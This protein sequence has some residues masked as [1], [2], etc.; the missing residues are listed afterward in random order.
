MIALEDCQS[1]LQEI[2][3]RYERW[4]VENALTEAISDRQAT[5]SFEQMVQTEEKDA[6]GQLKK[7][8]PLPIFTAIQNYIESEHILLVGSPGVGKSTALWC[9]LVQL[10]E[11]EREKPEPRIPVLISLKRYNNRFSCPEDPSGILALIKDTLEPDL[12]L[13]VPDIRKLLFKD[14]R[15]ILLLDG[16]NEMSAGEKRTE[17]EE[18]RKK[19]DRSK[20]PLIC[21]TRELGG[22]DL[23]IKRRLEIQP[24]ISEEVAR[25]LQDCIPDRKQK[26]SQLLNRDNRPLSRTPFVLWMLY[27]LFQKQGTKVETLAEAFRQFFQS[28]KKY[29]E[30]APVSEDRRQEWNRW[31]EHL[32]FTMLNHPDP[33]DP[34]LV[35]SKE[36]A[37]KSLIEKFGDLYGASS[38]IEELLKYHLLEE[39][40]EKEISFHHQLIQ[41]YYAA[42]CLLTRLP[43]LLK[44][45]RGQ[46]YTPFQV[47]YLNYVK[48][49]EAIA[50]MLGFPEVEENAEQ[51]I[52]SALD[53]DLYLT[54][55]LA[56]EFNLEAQEKSLTLLIS[57]CDRRD[58]SLLFKVTC[59]NKSRSKHGTQILIKALYE[60]DAETQ[61]KA[62][63]GLREV[64]DTAVIQDLLRVIENPDGRTYPLVMNVIEL[65]AVLDPDK[66]ISPKLRELLKSE[67]PGIREIAVL[68][69]R[70]LSTE[71]C[72][73]D[74]VSALKDPAIRLRKAVIGALGE[75]GWQEIVPDLLKIL[76]GHGEEYD[77]RIFSTAAFAL[78]KLDAE[79]AFSHPNAEVRRAAV[80]LLDEQNA[81]IAFSKLRV[82][83]QDE[84]FVV[85]GQAVGIVGRLRISEL[86][87]EVFLALEDS[88]STVQMQAAY[89]LG[90]LCSV[91]AIPK[92]IEKLKAEDAR[93]RKA[94]IETIRNLD[95]EE[96]VPGLFTA[97][98]DSEESVRR[99]A[100]Y[101]LGQLGRRNAIPHFIEI[102]LN[103]DDE[104]H[105]I[106]IRNYLQKLDPRHKSELV[107]QIKSQD[108]YI[109]WDA[110]KT[111]ARIA[112][113]AA[114]PELIRDFSEEK[115][116]GQRLRF[117]DSLRY[118]YS[119][120]VL[121]TLLDALNDEE[122]AIRRSAALAIRH[123]G[124]Y[125]HLR[126]LWRQQIRRPLEAI[127]RAISAI[128]SHC[129]FYNHEIY[130]SS[131]SEASN[132]AFQ[133]QLSQGLTNV[134]NININS[135]ANVGGVN[136]DST[137]HGSQIGANYNYINDES[138]KQEIAE[139]RLLVNQLQ[140]TRQPTTEAEA[141]QVIDAEF[142]EIQ[143]T[144]PNR[145]QAI[146]KQLKLL[147]RQLLNPERHLAA[148]KAAI[149]EVAK[150]YLEDSIIAKALITYVDTMSA[151]PDQGE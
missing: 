44:K 110:V 62:L 23:G 59:L 11:T 50:I 37:E 108:S 117:I 125:S 128:Q 38:R 97:L 9:C 126:E 16:L 109:R 116:V 69:L 96:A 4:W 79:K 143:R 127:D 60:H 145:W 49:T 93:T 77:E 39:I 95:S 24:L 73:P 144:N 118:T 85:R 47:N 81:E 75:I 46:Q 29:K 1:Y 82:A 35:I 8:P 6:E 136:V 13:E 78:A 25:F 120:E 36:Q 19:C 67:Y 142:H 3:R 140:Q 80:A 86:T 122:A 20:V 114:I 135:G 10:V 28:F 88:D 64:A 121:P 115:R 133:K 149:S 33:T 68:A 132:T 150:H 139:L 17:L 43:D 18:F 101:A 98:V 14:K 54:A 30:D 12:W 103:S 146:Q 83:L 63:E 42:E 56:G 41:E 94:A 71:A 45:Q 40:S 129:G 151:N 15:L 100:L 91:E 26:V 53:I 137:V 74:L 138:F 57:E 70:R 2:C 134:T 31:L 7:I 119:E 130:Q 123:L 51:L 113:H 5:F 99:S 90:Q 87:E 112:S 124:N 55:R 106:L 92:L 66:S 52:N 104:Y 34:G 148:S 131:R 61:E 76:D 32:A 48:W 102:L 27:D 65:L 21:T 22:G 72:I 107:E 105:A 147:K 141:I 84:N 58:L 89:A 111:L